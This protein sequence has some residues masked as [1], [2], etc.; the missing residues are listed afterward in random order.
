MLQELTIRNFA[1]L[2]EVHLTFGP[3]LNVLT[4]ETG[5]G[6]SIIIDAIGTVL[7]GRTTNDVVRTGTDRATVEAIFELTGDGAPRESLRASLDDAGLLDDDSADQLILAR[8][9]RRDG[10]SVARINGRAVPASVL[11]QIGAGLIDIHGQ[12]EHLSLLR[13]EAQRDLLDH[14]G[15]LVPQRSALAASVHELRAVRAQLR[16]IQQ[17]EREVAR[18]IDLLS[19]QVE[20]IQNAKLSP[21]EDDALEQERNL[22]V[23]AERL[24][25]LASTIY[26]RLAGGGGDEPAALDL[27]GGAARD[28]AH[29][30]RIDPQMAAQEQLLVEAS[31]QVEEL[32]RAFRA[33]R[34]GIEFSP[35]R[36]EEVNERLDQ[37]RTLQRKYGE[38]IEDVLAFG[39][40]VAAELDAL[41]NREA[42]TAELEDRAGRLEHE[43]GKA[44][45]ALSAARAA[46]GER[47]AS[48]VG[49]ELRALSLGG[50][51]LVSL[52][53]ELDAGGVPVDGERLRF[54][55][56]G[57][58]IVEFRFAP[59]PGEPA[60]P[61]ARTASGGE[62]SRILLALKA[63]LSAADRTP[64]LIFDEVD[65]G[66]GGRSG[67]ILGEKL[68]HL[69]RR[70]QVLCVTH[71]PQI[72]AY[73]DSHFYISKHVR[74]GRTLTTVSPLD[75]EARAHELAQMLGGLT[76]HTLE[77]GR[78]LQASAAN[79]K[80]G[81]PAVTVASVGAGR[82]GGAVTAIESAGSES[83]AGMGG[84]S[85]GGTDG[86]AARLPRGRA[87]RQ[88]KR[89]PLAGQPA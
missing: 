12:H 18:R 76:A 58:D 9:V 25:E 26:E 46:A 51:F 67:G 31:A 33:Y 54:D 23:N 22:L 77:Q 47:L 37:I 14:F 69:A 16:A 65:T 71:L 89:R 24:A 5:A 4:G 82:D 78:A 61:V 45:G 75:Q 48:A 8:E 28:L 32:A 38:T 50:E 29:L 79:W 43:I 88:A 19:F 53:R 73:G 10:R 17:D 6:K 52:M 80:A 11:A 27:L 36:L 72:A 1:L 70:H 66:I 21:G 86:A 35:E 40:R 49:E 83:P 3:G 39:A 55:E 57:V 44:A 87:V 13:P 56:S 15:G 41:V 85:T 60:K 34:E 20:E 68:A 59:N 7:G 81:A 42:R 2:E 74:D 63:V 30:T 64:T 62:L 84:D